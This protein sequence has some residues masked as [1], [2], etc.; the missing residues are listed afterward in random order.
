MM[1][2]GPFLAFIILGVMAVARVFTGPAWLAIALGL[3]AAVS[4]VTALVMALAAAYRRE[5]K[6]N[7]EPDDTE[8]RS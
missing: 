3:C 5:A 6:E 8:N 4:L 7:A 2:L 1:A